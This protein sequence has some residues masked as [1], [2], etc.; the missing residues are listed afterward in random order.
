[1]SKYI[2]T[3]THHSISCARHIE[4]NG[5]LTQAKRAATKEFGGEFLDYTIV[6]GE[7]TGVDRYGCDIVETV[8]SRK[9]GAT[10][11]T[12]SEA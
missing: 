11:W 7:V 9:V 6:I 12:V 8:A 1:M 4:V 3:I 5:T 2:A 10:G